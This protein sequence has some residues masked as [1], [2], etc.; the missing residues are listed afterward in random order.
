[1]SK[2]KI[3]AHCLIKNEDR[4][5]WYS[6][7]SVLPFVDQ[8]LVYDTGSTDK[9]L[10]IVKS[11]NSP[12]IK[13][14]EVGEV[15][16]NSFTNVRNQMLKDTPADTSWLMILDGDEV[17]PSPSI[18]KVIEFVR[19]NPESESIVVKTN[20]LVGDIYHRSPDWAGQYHLAGKVGH[21]NLRFI[22]LKKVKG[23]HLE[24]PHGQQGYYDGDG[25]LIQDRSG[26]EFLDVS[27]SHATHL[28][29]SGNRANDLTVI[30]R[31]K[32]YKIELGSKIKSGE[33]PEIFF[34][35]RPQIIP[36]VT[37]HAPIWYFLFALTLTIPKYLK[38][39]FIPTRHGY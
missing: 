5:I 3:V 12:K 19:L 10:D 32:K 34:Q 9:T 30:K 11:I 15:D 17:W 26:V 39:L 24:K 23:L 28:Q 31:A 22:N 36:D 7:Q 35:K 27:Y 13:F 6:L 18:K 14:K 4:F 20:N 16:A 8:I 25:K 33:L 37:V 38:H 2:T 29:R 1:M 21:L